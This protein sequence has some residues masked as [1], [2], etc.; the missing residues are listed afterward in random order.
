MKKRKG[1]KGLIFLISIVVLII[2]FL[3]GTV[4]YALARQNKGREFLKDCGRVF[5]G[6]SDV[7]AETDN[8]IYHIKTDN[9]SK[10]AKILTTAIVI[11]KDGDN[12]ETGRKIEFHSK[13]YSDVIRV[14]T[15]YELSDGKIRVTTES[16]EDTSTIDI[17]NI[18]FNSVYERVNT[19][20]LDVPGKVDNE[21]FTHFPF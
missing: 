8:T 13:D 2:G 1:T 5:T 3:L 4:I 12:T 14:M 17:T 20:N 6:N 11:F 10:I 21:E 18:R 9:N 15:I 19:E 7:Y 16:P